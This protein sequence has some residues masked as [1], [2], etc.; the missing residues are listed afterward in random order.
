MQY[1][2]IV[3]V[4]V[5]ES[6]EERS[7]SIFKDKIDVQDFQLTLWITTIHTHSGSIHTRLTK[8]Q[9]LTPE[10]IH[11]PSLS[12]CHSNQTIHI[13]LRTDSDI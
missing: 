5:I 11:T 2:Y 9:A 4:C 8:E 3:S 1:S 12:A 13:Q 6:F 7:V 10:G